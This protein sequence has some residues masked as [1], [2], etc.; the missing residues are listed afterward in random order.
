LALLL[1]R[2]RLLA[3]VLEEAPACH[4]GV[5]HLQGAAAGVDLVVMGQI[6]EAFEHAEQVLVPRA[7]PDLHVVSAALRTEWSEAGELVA[8]FWRRRHGE[9]AE[10]T[11]QVESLTLAGLP[12][13]LAKAD[14]DASPVLVDSGSAGKR[15]A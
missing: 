10:R 15:S 6:G 3:R 12:R 14:A 8:A 7:S 5:E 4:L 13:I 1:E 2:L 11:H 9:A